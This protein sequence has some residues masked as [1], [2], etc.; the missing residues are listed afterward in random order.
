MTGDGCRMPDVQMTEML[1]F[2]DMATSGIGH[3]TPN[4][5]RQL[6]HIC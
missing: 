2:N 4:P 5:C 3:R 6:V 1:L